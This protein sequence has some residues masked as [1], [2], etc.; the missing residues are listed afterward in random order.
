MGMRSS[1]QPGRVGE[2]LGVAYGYIVYGYS[3]IF[4]YTVTS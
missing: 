3:Y 4:T 1:D 2:L